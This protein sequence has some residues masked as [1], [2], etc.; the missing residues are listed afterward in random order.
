MNITTQL[1]ESMKE[2][3][4]GV[5]GA[6]FRGALSGEH[7]A[8]MQ[9]K[10]DLGRAAITAYES[11]QPAEEPREILA[12]RLIDTWCATHGKQIPWSK[13]ITILA[14]VTQMSDDERDRL[15]NLGDG[16]TATTPDHANP[17]DT[18]GATTT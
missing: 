7:F 17:L 11:Q 14:I 8:A 13:A 4:D 12:G 15:L 16:D 1:Y 10:L 2:I 6:T 3:I 18:F 5:N 9:A